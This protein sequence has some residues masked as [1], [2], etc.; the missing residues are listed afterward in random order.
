MSNECVDIFIIQIEYAAQRN[1]SLK[2]L[3]TK[4]AQLLTTRKNTSTS[5][6]EKFKFRNLTFQNRYSPSS[7]FLAVFRN[8]III[9]ESVSASD[10]SSNFESAEA[11]V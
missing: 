5:L 6:N 9:R 10:K 2:P 7:C 8:C 4:L 3:Y 11:M 1:T